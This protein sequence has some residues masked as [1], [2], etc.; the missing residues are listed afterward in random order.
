MVKTNAESLQKT[1]LFFKDF[2]LTM[3]STSAFLCTYSCEGSYFFRSAQG[4]AAI[5]DIFRTVAILVDS[6]NCLAML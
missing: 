5:N 2:V 4:H 1:T 6:L 3:G